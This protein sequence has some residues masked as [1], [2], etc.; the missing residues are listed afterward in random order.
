MEGTVKGE[1]IGTIATYMYSKICIWRTPRVR[2][3]NW[4]T[5]REFKDHRKEV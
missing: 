4:E 3:R 2:K 5:R 1:L